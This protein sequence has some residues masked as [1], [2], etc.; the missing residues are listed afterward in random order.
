MKK[1]V[2]MPGMSD[3]LQLHAVFRGRVQG[4]G[5]RWTILDHAEGFRLSGTVQNLKD[6]SV[7]VYAQGSKEVLEAFI[8]AVKQ[9]PGSAKVNSVIVEF[10]PLNGLSFENFR[11]I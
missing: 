2:T 11:I 10:Q 4:V 9:N 5:F 6:G 3:V 8:K 1:K 7:E